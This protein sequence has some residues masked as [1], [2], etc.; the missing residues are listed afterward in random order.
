[1]KDSLP[2][3]PDG[4]FKGVYSFAD[5]VNTK[6]YGGHVYF[7]FRSMGMVTK[8]S[9]SCNV[10]QVV[11]EGVI[12]YFDSAKKRQWVHHPAN[13]QL[14]HARVEY[15]TLCALLAESLTQIEDQLPYTVPL[16]QALTGIAELTI[17]RY[18]AEDPEMY[19]YDYEGPHEKTKGAHVSKWDPD[20]DEKLRLYGRGYTLLTHMAKNE[21]VDKAVHKK[22]GSMEDR[23]RELKFCE[24][25][26]VEKQLESMEQ[27][28]MPLKLFEQ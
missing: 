20:E 13:I 16:H 9:P 18:A 27:R 14:I 22:R 1:M 8:L 25:K 28:R 19:E 17:P 10:P 26:T 5:W 7:A 21:Y 24:D 15:N 6:V 11:P 12:G 2:T 4:T 3:G 23:R